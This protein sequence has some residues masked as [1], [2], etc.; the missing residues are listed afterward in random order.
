MRRKVEI[1]FVLDNRDSRLIIDWL[2]VSAHDWSCVRAGATWAILGHPEST[3]IAQN[4]VSEWPTS[5][6][7]DPDS[8]PRGPLEDLALFFVFPG[9]SDHTT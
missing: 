1:N 5:L 8:D 6:Q 4:H 7:D 9:E 2:N 3:R